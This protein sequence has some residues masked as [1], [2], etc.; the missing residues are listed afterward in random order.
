MPTAATG[1]GFVPRRD[2][3]AGTHSRVAVLLHKLHRDH[4]HLAWIRDQPS[5]DMR[6]YAAKSIEQHWSAVLNS[7]YNDYKGDPPDEEYDSLNALWSAVR[8]WV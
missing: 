1:D 7:I 4:H 2:K 6:K 5:A 3:R 8:S